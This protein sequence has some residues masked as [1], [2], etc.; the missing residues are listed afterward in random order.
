MV[1]R[2]CV[3]LTLPESSSAHR[4]PVLTRS[5]PGPIGLWR[6]CGPRPQHVRCCSVTAISR[7]CSLCDGATFRCPL[8]PIFVWIP[9]PCRYSAGTASFLPSLAGTADIIEHEF[10]DRR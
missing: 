7:G 5:A 3:L 6:G 1:H 4:G 10:D 9:R 8:V 2:R